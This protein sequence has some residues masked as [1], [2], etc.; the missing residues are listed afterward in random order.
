MSTGASSDTF[1]STQTSTS[2]LSS[3]DAQPF[4]TSA[5][6]SHVIGTVFRSTTDT[7]RSTGVITPTSL[8]LPHSSESSAGVIIPPTTIFSSPEVTATVPT[9]FPSPPISPGVV[10]TVEAITH[11]VVT[12]NSAGVLT[13]AVVVT[14][15]PIATAEAITRFVVTTNSAGVTTESAEFVTGTP[16]SSSLPLQLQSKRSSTSVPAPT[17][18]NETPASRRNSSIVPAIVGSLLGALVLAIWIFFFIRCRR[19]RTV[20]KLTPLRDIENDAVIQ[21]TQTFARREKQ[22]GRVITAETPSPRSQSPQLDNDNV[23]ARDDHAIRLQLQMAVAMII[24]Q[25]GV[26]DRERDLENTS[27][28]EPPPTYVSS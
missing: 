16:S 22:A 9:T 2:A 27:S 18:S 14:T 20:H 19:R 1:E 21:P 15:E 13:T 6:A 3:F 25:M 26:S 12:T 8:P 17:N 4:F 23:P 5:T 11:L 7:F 10:T 28:N 24:Q